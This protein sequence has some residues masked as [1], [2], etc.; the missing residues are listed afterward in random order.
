MDYEDDVEVILHEPYPVTNTQKVTL[1]CPAW[2]PRDTAKE[3]LLDALTG[4][5]TT[6]SKNEKESK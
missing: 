5:R 4:N 2:F 3:I 6:V 1:K